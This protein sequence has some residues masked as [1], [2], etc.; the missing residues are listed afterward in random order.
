MLYSTWGRHDGDAPN[1]EC[2]GYGDF[3]SMTA[4]TTEGYQLYAAAVNAG[5]GASPL[6]APAGIAFE[7]VFNKSGTDPLANTS[8]FSCL[9]NHGEEQ[10]GQRTVS[11]SGVCVLNGAGLG[12]HPSVEGSYLISMV[13]AETIFQQSVEGLEWA[14]SGVSPSTATFLQTIAHSVVGA[15]ADAQN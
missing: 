4:L 2:C 13:L 8:R 14:P 9:Y 1:A 15:A 7:A 6:V 5:T 12:G 10:E 11:D 3:L